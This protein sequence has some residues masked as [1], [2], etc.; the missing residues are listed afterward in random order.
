ML[1]GAYCTLSLLNSYPIAQPLRSIETSIS[2]NFLGSFSRLGVRDLPGGITVD[3]GSDWVCLNKKF[4]V[5]FFLFHPFILKDCP[6]R[7]GGLTWHRLVF[8]YFLSQAVPWATRLLRHH[9]FHP[10]FFFCF[11]HPRFVLNCKKSSLAII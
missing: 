2:V 8:V 4:V 3:G 7:G 10:L 9:L 1:L 11:V 5:S 6:G